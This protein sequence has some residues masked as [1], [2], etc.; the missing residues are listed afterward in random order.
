MNNLQ[1]SYLE[2]QGWGFFGTLAQFQAHVN[3]AEALVDSYIPIQN[4]V[5]TADEAQKTSYKKA[6]CAACEGLI[7]NP[8]GVVSSY[9]AGKVSETFAEVQT[10]ESRVRN[11]LSGSGLLSM[12]A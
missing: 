5:D 9:S 1:P 6:I 2:Y 3:Q 10:I 8:D 12:W 11:Y 4:V 7:E